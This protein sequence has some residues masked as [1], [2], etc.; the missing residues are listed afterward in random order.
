MATLFRTCALFDES[1]VKHG[2]N[3]LAAFAEFKKIKES[4]AM[5]PFGSK[6]RPFTGDGPLGMHKPRI[7]HAGMT[8]DISL[9]YSISGQNPQII[10]LYGFFTHDESGIGQ[11]SKP[12]IQKAVVKKIS[13]QEMK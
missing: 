8:K 11:P 4:N 9:F 6:D 12:N 2:R 7:I 1:L 3:V 5:T 10:S 13:N